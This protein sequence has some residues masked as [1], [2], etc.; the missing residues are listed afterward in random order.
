[1]AAVVYQRDV[2]K[3]V[4]NP[5]RIPAQSLNIAYRNLY[6]LLETDENTTRYYKRSGLLSVSPYLIGIHLFVL[7]KNE[8]AVIVLKQYW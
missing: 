2:N 3:R 5:A 7:F 1:M 4:M 8:T 6:H